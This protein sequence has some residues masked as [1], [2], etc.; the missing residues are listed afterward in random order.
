M[1][2]HMQP[3]FVFHGANVR[4]ACLASRFQLIRM[5]GSLPARGKKNLWRTGACLALDETR[6]HDGR[7]GRRQVGW[8]CQVGLRTVLDSSTADPAGG[9]RMDGRTGCHGRQQVTGGGSAGLA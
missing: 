5:L 7:D 8:V 4:P 3:H 6:Q 1:C 2:R 9:W